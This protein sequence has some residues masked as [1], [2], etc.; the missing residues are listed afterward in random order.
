MTFVT[1]PDWRRSVKG[2]FADS[3]LA[4]C[5]ECNDHA[6]VRTN[7]GDAFCVDCGHVELTKHPGRS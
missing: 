3:E 7:H 2:W 6:L 1:A 5:P 4:T